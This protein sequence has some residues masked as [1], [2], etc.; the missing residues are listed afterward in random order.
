LLSNTLPS[1]ATRETT[2]LLSCARIQC[3]ACSLPCRA[4]PTWH[5]LLRRVE[6]GGRARETEAWGRRRPLLSEH[7]WAAGGEASMELPGHRPRAA[8][9]PV[10]LAVYHGFRSVRPDAPLGSLVPEIQGFSFRR[11]CCEASTACFL[12]KKYREG[13]P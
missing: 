6:R 7:R 8:F 1:T 2:T 9:Q 12:G 4:A 10:G 13:C 11:A 3:L 5:P